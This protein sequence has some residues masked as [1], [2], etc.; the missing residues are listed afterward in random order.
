MRVLL[1]IQYAQ[2]VALE[3]LVAGF[4]QRFQL[5]GEVLL[6]RRLIGLAAVGAADGVDA[7]AQPLDAARAQYI[8]CQGDD[9][10]VH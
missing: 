2:G 1:A 3:A 9:F 7:H 6:Q 4:A 10:R 8:Q 5:A